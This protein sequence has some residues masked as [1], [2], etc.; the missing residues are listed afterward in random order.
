MITIGVGDGVTVNDATVDLPNYLALNGIV[1][2]IDVVLIPPIE[3]GAPTAAPTDAS[4]AFGV[5]ALVAK[6]VA[7]LFFA[8]Q[9]V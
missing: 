9:M 8:V 3:T 5:S 6:I 2:G 1:H 7:G 4:A